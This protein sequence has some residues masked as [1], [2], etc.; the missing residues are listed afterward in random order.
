MVHSLVLLFALV[1][2]PNQ[3]SS[4]RQQGKAKVN[5]TSIY[6]ETKGEGF[7]LVLVSG[8]GILDVLSKQN[9]AGREKVRQIYLDNKDVFEAGFP[10]YR[11]WQP[12]EPP[13]ETRLSNIRAR[14][15]IIRGDH[16]SPVYAAM[17]ER[18]S[19]GIPQATTVVILGGTHFINLE[20]P[21]EFNKTV[22]GFLKQSHK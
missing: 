22:L 7:P 13:P 14:V 9:I 8:G 6:Y 19:K 5:G 18:V 20:E 12:I 3:H 15:L 4:A 1:L 21:E 10:L 17:T 2:I 11:L 16:D